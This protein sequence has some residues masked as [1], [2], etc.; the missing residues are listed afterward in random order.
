MKLILFIFLI[1]STSFSQDKLSDWTCEKLIEKSS[2][3]DFSL[4]VL[5][6][7]RA[8]KNC[9]NF[10]YDWRSI[11]EMDKKIYADEMQEIDPEFKP[12]LNELSIKDLKAQLKNEKNPTEKF[13]IYRQLRQKYRNNGQKDDARRT[14]TQAYKWAETSWHKDKKDPA[15]SQIFID[16]SIQMARI[17]WNADDHKKGLQ[18]LDKVIKAL[19]QENL[20]ELYFVKA[21]MVEEDKDYDLAVEN[22]NKCLEQLAT[23]KSKSNSIDPYRISWSK[24]WLLYKQ[25]K[26]PEA[27]KALLEHSQLG[28]D[29][30]EKSRADFFRARTLTYQNKKDEAQKILEKIIEPDFYSYYSLAS[31]HELNKK[32]PPFA[33]LKSKD[34]FEFDSSLE[35]IGK[36]ERELFFDLIKYSEFSIAEKSIQFIATN[37]NQQTN[38]AIYLANKTQRYLP[39]FTY[40]A[41]LTNDEKWDV[42]IEHKN[43]VFPI[44]HEGPVKKMSEKTEL[45]MSLIY[46]IMKQES[47]FNPDSK[48]HAN[49]LGL[50]QVIPRLAK[51]LAKKYKINYRHELDLL[52]PEIN[53]ELGSFELKD[54]V[55]KQKGQL[56]FVAAAYNAGPGALSNWL[57]TKKA[58]RD[59]FEFIEDIPYDETRMYVKIIARNKLFYERILN[60][61]DEIEFPKDFVQLAVSN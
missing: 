30:T 22:Y 8:H 31:Y 21:K 59:I 2:D 11:S 52:N 40:F 36:K 20:I 49:A 3:K 33:K 1:A 39:L 23:K 57:K 37:L 42:L 10:K 5:A 25:E 7:L 16:A 56:T 15:L 17:Q 13:K 46:A 9:K 28:N 43:L 24:A 60:P 18:T 58:E 4:N 53:I 51:S 44:V 50:M 14:A 29:L 32:F 27:E 61:K 35:K 47:G 34:K 54:Q 48:S 19:P 12:P 26:W 38:M 45:P 6:G 55:S 41:R